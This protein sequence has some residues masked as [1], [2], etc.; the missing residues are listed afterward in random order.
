M[1]IRDRYNPEMGLSASAIDA[2]L[3]DGGL[4][5]TASDRAARAIAA[6]FHR[7]R[8]AEG[9]TAWPA[10]HIQDWNTFVRT[11]WEE[12]SRALEDPRLLLNPT[13][14]R[15]IWVEIAGAGQHMAATLE[16][17]RHRL[18]DL[19]IEAHQLLAAY[20]PPLLSGTCLLYTSRCV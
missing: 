17:P 4:L 9:L 20:A 16:G 18:A 3:R 5:V 11:A 1:C 19:T 7:A 8:R 2:W 10:P 15:A 12:R 14:E 13:Q 6:T